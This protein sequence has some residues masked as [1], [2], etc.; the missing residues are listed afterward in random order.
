M[1]ENRTLYLVWN[2]VGY[3]RTIK[4]YHAYQ[5]SRLSPLPTF[6]K[7]CGLNVNL[8]NYKFSFENTVFRN[9]CYYK[10]T[11]PSLIVLLSFSPTTTYWPRHCKSSFWSVLWCFW[12]P[13]G[14][15]YG[16]RFVEYNSDLRG[17]LEPY[18]LILIW[19][20]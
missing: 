3:T 6:P 11:P 12:S 18:F 1:A 16:P 20:K 15:S 14:V 4:P 7:F 17:L 10:P 8:G 2:G 5:L 9:Q 13:S 19:L